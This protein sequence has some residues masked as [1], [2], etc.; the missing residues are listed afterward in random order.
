MTISKLVS[1]L[2]KSSGQVIKAKPR[3]LAANSSGIVEIE[4]PKPI[5]IENYSDFKDLGRI[6]L[7]YRGAT[8]AAG[9]VSKVIF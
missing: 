3:C 1:Q 2:D 7:R 4:T 5:S 9:L 8:V 6:M